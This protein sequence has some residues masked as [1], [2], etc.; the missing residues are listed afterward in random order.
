MGSRRF[1]PGGGATPA[2]RANIAA[3][4]RPGLGLLKVGRQQ[5]QG[6]SEVY[7]QATGL[8]GRERAFGW[9]AIVHCPVTRAVSL[10]TLQIATAG[11]EPQ[12]WLLGAVRL[13]LPRHSMPVTALSPLMLCTICDRAQLCAPV[14]P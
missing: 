5:L 1:Q 10:Q 8:R 9:T 6:R 3:A 4:L 14:L 7:M 12:R 11:G 2:A 13:L